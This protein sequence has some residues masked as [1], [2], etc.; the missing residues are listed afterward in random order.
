MGANA[1]CCWDGKGS[2]AGGRSGNK[3]NNNNLKAPKKGISVQAQAAAQQEE[4]GG[5]V[6]DTFAIDDGG[7]NNEQ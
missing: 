7:E 3:G 1:D 6:N 5:N 2:G 4:G